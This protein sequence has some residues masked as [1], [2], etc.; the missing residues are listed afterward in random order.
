MSTI[1]SLT[2]SAFALLAHTQK[3]SPIFY[4]SLRWSSHAAFVTPLTRRLLLVYLR[5]TVML[6]LEVGPTFGTKV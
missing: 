3:I 1:R 5:Q 4:R 2:H 6:L